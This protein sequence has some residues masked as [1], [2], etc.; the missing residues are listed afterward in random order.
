LTTVRLDISAR[1]IVVRLPAHAF[2]MMIPNTISLRGKVIV[3]IGDVAVGP[4]AAQP[5]VVAAA[6]A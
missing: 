3:G 4:S 2:S 5:E 1:S 6:G